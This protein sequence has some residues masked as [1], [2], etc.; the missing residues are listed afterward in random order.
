MTYML[1]FCEY[2]EHRSV[3]FLSKFFYRITKSIKIASILFCRVK[4]GLKSAYPC[5]FP[6]LYIA[7]KTG[8][9]GFKSFCPCHTD[10]LKNGLF[11]PFLRLF[12]LFHAVLMLREWVK[13]PRFGVYLVF[14]GIGLYRELLR[15][16]AGFWLIHLVPSACFF[17][18]AAVD[19]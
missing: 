12:F 9:R 19:F 17:D 6:A 1:G 16:A 2:S 5:A 3:L 11:K 8:C 18:F 10:G 14:M 13:N 4:N 7:S 15:F